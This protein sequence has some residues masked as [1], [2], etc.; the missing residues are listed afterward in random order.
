MSIQESL[1]FLFD[2]I[3]LG[4]IFIATIDFSREVIILYRQTFVTPQQPILLTSQ[5]QQLSQLPDPWL[6]ATAEALNSAEQITQVQPKP[7]LLLAPAKV[8]DKGRLPTTKSA[9]KELLVGVNVDTL[10]L[11]DA[12]KLAKALGIAQKVDG[13]DQKLESLRSQIEFKLQQSLLPNVESVVS[14]ELVAC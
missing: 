9:T 7:I 8:V 11:R 6:L 4:F 2:A 1:T 10:K 14:E 3:A 13:R 12:R 5:L